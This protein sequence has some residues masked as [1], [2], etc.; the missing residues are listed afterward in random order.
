M[1]SFIK[2]IRNAI[3]LWY[4]PL[5]T[6]LLW[7]VLG[8]YIF[9]IPEETYL[10][11]AGFFTVSLLI[12]GVFETYFSIQNRNRIEGWGGYL[13][14]GILNLLVGLVL[15]VYP[16]L[17]LI[18][19]PLVVGFSLLFRSAQGLGF[20]FDLKKHG[21]INWRYLAMAGAL[22]IVFSMFMIVNPLF[23]SLSLVVMT[24]LTC[25]VAGISGIV[26]SFNLKKLKQIT[27]KAIRAEFKKPYQKLKEEFQD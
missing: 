21:I 17:S 9:T 13:A 23:T 12:S 19:L 8:I 18:T 15:L 3:R 24:G 5:I 4:V 6:G 16:V 25:I 26:L 7:L 10:V 1:A 14:G 11:L 27:D 22:G 20:A 2:A